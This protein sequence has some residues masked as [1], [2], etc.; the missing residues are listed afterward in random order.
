MTVVWQRPRQRRGF[1]LTH[2]VYNPDGTLRST[3]YER[4]AKARSEPE[5]ADPGRR[6]LLL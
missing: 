1:T 3:V 5:Q 6:G 2:V 4:T